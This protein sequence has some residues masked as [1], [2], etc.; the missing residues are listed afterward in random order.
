MFKSIWKSVFVVYITLIIIFVVLK[1]DGYVLNT[2]QTIVPR[3]V[4][5]GLS[6]NLSPFR[7]MGVFI[8]NIHFGVGIKNILGNT[9]PFIPMGFLFPMAF[10]SRRSFLKTMGFCLLI[11][12]SIEIL[13][14]FFKLSSFD[15]GDFI[16]N[17]FSC[18]LGF[19]LFIKYKNVVE[20]QKEE[21]VKA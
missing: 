6:V 3:K 19:I 2:I 20:R 18:L 16:L 11:I 4:Q 13:Q 8:S 21:F 17:L 1:F 12:S 9:I 7:T 5:W 15:I 14:F 10:P